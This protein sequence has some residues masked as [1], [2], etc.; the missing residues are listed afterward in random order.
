MMTKYENIKRTRISKKEITKEFTDDL[1]RL[2][3]PRGNT[4]V[5][6]W[7]DTIVPSLVLAVSPY[8]KRSLFYKSYG[9]IKLIGD[10]HEVTVARAREIAR[11]VEANIEEV[12]G[13]EFQDKVP[14]CR[15][16]VK[17]GAFPRKRKVEEARIDKEAIAHEI[18][19]AMTILA[20]AK[21]KLL[22]EYDFRLF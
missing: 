10:V 6:Y 4:K 21:K 2:L 3:A 19:Q 9:Y 15:D 20:N 22:S 8:E 13:T 16:Y 12:M 1:V 11:N 17:N 14:L 18:N 5:T 7:R